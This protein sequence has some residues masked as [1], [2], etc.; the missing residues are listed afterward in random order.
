MELWPFPYSFL[1]A[2][3]TA[4]RSCPHHRLVELIRVEVLDQDAGRR[5]HFCRHCQGSFSEVWLV[6]NPGDVLR[7]RTPPVL[8]YLVGDLLTFVEGLDPLPAMLVWCTKTS[9]PPSS[10]ETK[11]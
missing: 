9:S 10:G 5:F 8:S 3:G 7:L 11:P 2:R 4:L 6:G 1:V